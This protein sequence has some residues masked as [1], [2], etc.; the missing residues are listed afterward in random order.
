MEY[1]ALI[2]EAWAITRRY[3]FLWIFG[4]FAGGAV[5]VWTGGG[6]GGNGQR[7]GMGPQDLGGFGP[8]AEQ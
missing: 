4:L 5:G 1:G 2:R 3:R 8:Q 6:A 7:R